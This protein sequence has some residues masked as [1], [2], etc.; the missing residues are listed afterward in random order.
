MNR[1]LLSPLGGIELDAEGTRKKR[2]LWWDE[3]S[4][5]VHAPP[6]QPLIMALNS[7]ISVKVFDQDKI[8]VCFSAETQNCKFGVGSKLKVHIFR[9]IYIQKRQNKIKK[10]F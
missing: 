7:Q 1:L 5:H 9:D 4:E 3:N 2:W 6:L 8:N 10:N